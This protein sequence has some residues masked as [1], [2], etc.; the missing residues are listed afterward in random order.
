MPP[1]EEIA[2]SIEIKIPPP[3]AEH[4]QDSQDAT[5]AAVTLAGV[6]GA[7]DAAREADDGE[8]ASAAGQADAG[9]SVESEPPPEATTA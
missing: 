4:R 5:P 6:G 1:L 8:D 2:R 7:I 9:S 3:T